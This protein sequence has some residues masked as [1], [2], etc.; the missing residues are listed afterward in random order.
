VIASDI[1]EVLGTAYALYLLIGMPIPVG[2]VVTALDTLLFLF[3]QYLSIR[4]LEVIIAVLLGII[5]LCFF[6]E[7]FWSKP[8]YL[9]IAAV[10]LHLPLSLLFFSLL[11]LQLA[12]SS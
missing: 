6:A 4:I 5:S 1:P 2:V 7:M 10:R 11:L 12:N 3:L 9:E 8:D